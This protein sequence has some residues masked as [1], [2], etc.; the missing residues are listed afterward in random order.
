MEIPLKDRESQGR[1]RNVGL[2]SVKEGGRKVAGVRRGSDCSTISGMFVTSQWHILE[3]I[4]PV[5]TGLH[6]TGM[7]L[8]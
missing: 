8:H 6:L 3:S 7:G 4:S 1:H 5:E 2:T